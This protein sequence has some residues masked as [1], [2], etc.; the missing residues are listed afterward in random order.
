M[1][2]AIVLCAGAST[3]FSSK[4]Q[5]KTLF[6]LRGK[7][8]FLYSIEKFIELG[9]KIVIVVRNNE[10]AIF[11]GFL[12]N[13]NISFVHGGQRRQDSVLNALKVLEEEERVLIHDGARPLVSVE[14]IQRVLAN[15]SLHRCVVPAI[16]SEDTLRIEKCGKLYFIDRK[17]IFRIQTPQ[18]CMAGELK[19]LYEKFRSQNF[20]DDAS[21]FE[22]AGLDVL[23]VPGEKSNLK[24]TTF[25]DVKFAD[26]FLS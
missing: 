10:E 25:E 23:A 8:V 24:I 2:T 15:I 9:M 22:R 14:L 26:F 13:E 3:R 5:N 21:A 4:G 16:P 7:P 12:R 17:K 19:E 1:S 20:Y 18:G 6:L 11:K